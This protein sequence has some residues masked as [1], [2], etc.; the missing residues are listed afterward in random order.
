MTF[1]EHLEELRSRLIRCLLALFVAACVCLVF[2]RELLNFFIRPY[3][4][5]RQSIS[6]RQA[7]GQP[8]Q[9]SAWSTLAD[10]LESKGV[11][12]E[13]DL[14]S[15]RE[16]HEFPGRDIG[17]LRSVQVTE[18]FMAHLKA[19]LLTAAL[20]AAPMILYQMWKFIG[21]GLYPTERKALLRVLPFSMAMFAVG[22]FFG[23][24]VLVPVSLDFL[25]AY[26]DPEVIDPEIRVGS[27]LSLLFVL[28]FVMGL[29]FQVPLVM[30]VLASVGAL[31]AKTFRERRKYFLL[32]AVIMAAILTPP[33][34][35]T[36][37]LVAAPLVVLYELGILLAWLAERRKTS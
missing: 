28:L 25:L 11:L 18:S 31:T 29:I 5:A 24:Y 14:E 30:T 13:Q 9:D 3:N 10:L 19:A 35:V 26:G 36:Q 32:G 20:L 37:L 27:Y 1:A 33:D 2:Q 15:W 17:P 6:A 7:G 23:F 8:T 12:S 4:T 21:A 22:L 16:S 34:Y